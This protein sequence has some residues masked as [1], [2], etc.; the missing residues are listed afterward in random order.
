MATQGWPQSRNGPG[1]RPPSPINSL[2]RP[3]KSAPAALRVLSPTAIT[4]SVDG[5][6]VVESLTGEEMAPRLDK[7]TGWREFSMLRI[8]PQSG[9]LTLTPAMTGLGEVRLDDLM[10]EVLE[11]GYGPAMP[12]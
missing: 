8:E 3:A 4:G 1:S 2:Q 6:L 9:P 11:P 12:R 7:T 10:I 5:L